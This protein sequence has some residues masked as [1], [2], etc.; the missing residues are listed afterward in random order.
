MIYT[1]ELK[2]KYNYQAVTNNINP[3]IGE[4]DDTDNQRQMLLT[5]PISKEGNTIVYGLS[6]IHI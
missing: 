6:L 4:Y 1:E 3:I 2:A 5:L